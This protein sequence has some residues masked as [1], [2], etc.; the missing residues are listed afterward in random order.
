LR[1]KNRP[2][3]HTAIRRELKKKKNSEPTFEQL[4]EPV[5]TYKHGFPEKK[6]LTIMERPAPFKRGR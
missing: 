1:D 4:E 6:W 5:T 2:T 3:F